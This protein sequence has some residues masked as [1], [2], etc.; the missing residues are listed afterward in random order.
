MKSQKEY[1]MESSYMELYLIERKETLD[2]TR[3]LMRFTDEDEV[4]VSC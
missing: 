2:M 4:S 3:N 1:N